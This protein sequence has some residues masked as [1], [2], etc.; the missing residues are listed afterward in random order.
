MFSSMLR[1][2]NIFLYTTYNENVFDTFITLFMWLDIVMFA[3]RNFL[4]LELFKF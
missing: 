2:Q 1:E 4:Q 3:S